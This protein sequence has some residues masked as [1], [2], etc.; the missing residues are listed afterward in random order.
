MLPFQSRPINKDSS[1]KA[2]GKAQR[3]KVNVKEQREMDERR[4]RLEQERTK[5]RA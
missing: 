2:S 3:L 1:R 5:K 4:A